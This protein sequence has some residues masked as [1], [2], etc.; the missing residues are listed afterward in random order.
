MVASV[1]YSIT[2]LN[3]GH[4]GVEVVH[5]GDE[6]ASLDFGIYQMAATVDRIETNANLFLSITNFGDHTLHH[7]FPS[8]DHALLPQLRS[9]LAETCLEFDVEFR[10]YTCLHALIQ[11]FKQLGRTTIIRLDRSSIDD[12]IADEKLLNMINNNNNSDMESYRNHKN[13]IL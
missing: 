3:A 6:F 5:E 4:H 12:N 8:L 7:L 2:A 9:V 10:K 13:K 1:L 11:Q